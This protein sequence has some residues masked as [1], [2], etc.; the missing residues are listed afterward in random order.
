MSKP[1]KRVSKCPCKGCEDRF[2]KDGHRC[3]STCERYIKWKGE[4]DGVAN[5]LR[6]EANKTIDA[7]F[8]FAE[9]CI[10]HKKAIRRCPKKG[11][12]A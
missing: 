11:S 10:R 12:R 5:Y 9:K 4:V 1:M 7:D 2:V 6:E 8:L 3:H